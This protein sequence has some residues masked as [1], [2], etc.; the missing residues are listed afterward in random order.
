MVNIAKLILCALL[1]LLVLLTSCNRNT[2]P[3]SNQ[4]NNDSIQKYIALAAV[5]SLPS[6][7]RNQ[8]NDKAFSLIAL[9]Q[10]D[11]LTRYYL[12]ET[13]F[14][15]LKQRNWVALK[16][17]A[18]VLLQ[19]ATTTKDTLNLARYYR[20]TAGYYKH[21][22]AYDSAFYCYS[23]AE[24]LYRK[25]G[26]N[27]DLG[28]ALFNKGV[29]QFLVNDF[30]G[31][32]FSLTQAE[33]IFK[34]QNN[35]VKRSEVLMSIGAI[36]IETKEIHKALKLNLAALDLI[37]EINLNAVNSRAICLNNIGNSYTELN[38][39]VLADHFLK[40]ALGIKELQKTSPGLE[41]TILF[42][43]ANLRI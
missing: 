9:D 38:N 8:Y 29:V 35:K 34:K 18:K 28:N 26:N 41:G 21:N 1:A 25:L 24:K 2:N 43:L 33:F 4:A 20:Y 5:D 12:S 27:N 30:L 13:P 16:K 40:E 17:T 6:Q 37:K 7:K 32:E 10:N 11:T 36:Y 31:A 23:K 3:D 39:L 19:K 14:N 22:K 15:N 42:N